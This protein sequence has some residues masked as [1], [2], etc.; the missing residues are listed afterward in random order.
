MIGFSADNYV[1]RYDNVCGMLQIPVVGTGKISKVIFYGNDG[2]PVAGKFS[3]QYKVLIE[4]GSSR[5][6]TYSP[7]P[8]SDSEDL[9]FTDRAMTVTD[10]ARVIYIDCG[11]GIQLDPDNA[12]TFNIAVFPQT[13]KNG[14]SVRFVDESNGGSFEKTTSQP[15]TIKRYY[16]KRMKAVEYTTPE[17]LEPA[18][19]FAIDAAGYYL[20]PAYCMG[21]RPISARLDVDEN[22]NYSATGN[23]VSAAWLWT[24]TPGWHIWMSDF[25]EVVTNGTCAGGTTEDGFVS[26][27]SKGRLVIMDRN[28]GAISA[29]KE[30]GWETYGLYYQPGRKDPFIGAKGAGGTVNVRF[31][32]KSHQ[33]PA[34]STY[35]SY[36]DSPFGEY[37]SADDE[38]V[39]RHGA[40][41]QQRRSRGLLEQNQD[42]KRSLPGWMD[43]LRR[44]GR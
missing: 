12:T 13:F 27:E 18:N 21:N 14:F 8:P 5:N 33:D 30:D 24:D 29:D 41:R 36:E 19:C 37:T 38:R 2:E 22:G 16:V 31:E 25:K 32:N 7:V 34:V 44:E 26:Q 42:H 28:L 43:Y 17:P 9:S 20:M 39:E 40:F 1:F 11:E 3:E 35:Y 23:P 15:I 6:I 4:S 10:T